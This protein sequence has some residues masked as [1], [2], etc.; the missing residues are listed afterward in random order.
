MDNEILITIGL[1]IGSIIYSYFVGVNDTQYKEVYEKYLKGKQVFT[2]F[3]YTQW[4]ITAIWTV[5]I[6]IAVS[7]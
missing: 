6:Y 7:N 3:N 4:I 2:T 1:V 5:I